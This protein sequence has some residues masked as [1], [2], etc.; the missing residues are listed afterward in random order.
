VDSLYITALPMSTSPP[1]ALYEFDS[2]QATQQETIFPG[3]L[4]AQYVLSGENKLDD[5]EVVEIL[6]DTPTSK[7]RIQTNSTHFF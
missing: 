1:E 3:H 5:D 2:R 6:D 7:A 4:D